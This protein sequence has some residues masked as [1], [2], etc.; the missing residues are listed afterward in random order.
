[1]EFHEGL[2]RLLL[3]VFPALRI[4]DIPYLQPARF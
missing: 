4:H 3:G 1:M 2:G